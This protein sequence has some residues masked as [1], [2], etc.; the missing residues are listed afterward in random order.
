M[1]CSH[2]QLSWNQYYPNTFASHWF[3]D[4]GQVFPDLKLNKL[5]HLK[6]PGRGEILPFLKI[7]SHCPRS[8][9]KTSF[10]PWINLSIDQS[11]Q[12]ACCIKRSFWKQ[13]RLTSRPSSHAFFATRPAPSMTLGFEV[14]VQLVM[15]A[16]TTLPC[17]IS[18]GFPW[19][20]NFTTLSCC[21]LGTPKPCNNPNR[22][23]RDPKWVYCSVDG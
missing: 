18:A 22:N 5:S 1:L 17:L 16:I 20:E 13:W 15:A 12:K 9:S 8:W 2:I 6:L 10:N 23:C 21:S 3:C 4:I 7:F 19:K 11:Y 14:F